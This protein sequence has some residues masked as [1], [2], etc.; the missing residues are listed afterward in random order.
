M[1]LLAQLGLA[2]IIVAATYFAM[3]RIAEHKADVLAGGETFRLDPSHP[4]QMRSF[5]DLIDQLRLW[6]QADFAESLSA[7]RE[8]GQLWIAP[9]S[10]GIAA[11]S[12]SARSA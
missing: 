2:I 7:L 11:P 6:K 1:R 9:H 10:G 4:G 5:D 12:T 8:K 3:V